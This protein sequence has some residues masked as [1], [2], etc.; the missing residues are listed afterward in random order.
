MAISTPR[1]IPCLWFDGQAEEAATFYTGIFDNARIVRVTRF[2]R[3]GQEI[4]G[5]EEGSVMTVD[6]EIDGQPFTALN[7]GP[8]FTFNEAISFQVMCESQEKLDYFW[9][10]LSEGG[11][12]A[13]Q[14]C[15]WLKDRFGVSWQVIPEGLTELVA[16][17]ESPRSQRAMKAMLAMKKLDLEALQ[18]AY[19][20]NVAV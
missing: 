8:A 5:R 6:F 15:G 17:P 1:I 18:W 14:Q 16:D 10:R 19:D 20:G 12:E 13:A 2:G 7:G 3:E 11:D 4:H 9:E